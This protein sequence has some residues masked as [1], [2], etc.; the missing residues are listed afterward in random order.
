MVFGT[1]MGPLTE[2]TP[3]SIK[4]LYLVVDDIADTRQLLLDR[5]VAVGEVDDMGGVS[6]AWFSDPD[7]N[8]WTLRQW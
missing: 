5:S 4:G 6:Y 1:G 7:W 2:M 8:L 3:G